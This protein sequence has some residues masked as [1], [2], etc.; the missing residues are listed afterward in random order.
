[1]CNLVR[2]EGQ[3]ERVSTMARRCMTRFLDSLDQ[4]TVPVWRRSL[5]L[6]AACLLVTS[7]IVS[8]APLSAKL[9]LKYSGAAFSMEELTVRE[10][11]LKCVTR[12]IQLR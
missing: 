4:D 2:Q 10:C 7:K 5:L 11:Y 8:Q 3:P 6:A 1:M 12:I 9:L